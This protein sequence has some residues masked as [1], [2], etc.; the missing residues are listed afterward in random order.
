MDSTMLAEYDGIVYIGKT[1]D[2][3]RNQNLLPD[4]TKL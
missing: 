2:K 4:V 3:V 1:L